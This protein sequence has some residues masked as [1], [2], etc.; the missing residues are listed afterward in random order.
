MG[1]AVAETR[2]GRRTAWIG[3]AIVLVGVAVIRLRLLDVPLERDEGE[4]AY[5]GARILD[6]VPPFAGA[7]T[8]KLP[9]T[10]ACYAVAMALF[11]R[12][13]AGIRTGLLLAN[14]ATIVLV[15]LAA[16]RLWGS[17]AGLAA[18][19]AFAGV[20]LSTALLGIYGHAT[21]FV[22][23]AAVGGFAALLLPERPLAGGRLLAA[24]ALF[25]LAIL[26]KQQG[27]VFA[28]LAASALVR[29]GSA[30][31]LPWFL[32]GVAAPWAAT[33]AL[34]AA[35]GTFDAFWFWTVEYAR[36]YATYSSLGHGL[37]RLGRR[38]AEA[39]PQLL[40]IA[41]L[42]LGG[43]A[44]LVA[45][46]A[47]RRDR[48]LLPALAGFAFAGTATGFYFRPHYLLLMAPA[49]AFLAA[50]ATERLARKRPAL[51]LAAIA[52]AAAQTVWAQR[53]LFFVATP[54]RVS[55]TLY[56]ASPFPEAVEVA[57]VLRER[58]APGD[59][60]AV[61]GS[62]PE[63]PFYAGLPSATGYLY[64]YGLM[65]AQP[66]ARRMQEQLIDEIERGRPRFV[67]YV[68][69]DT[70]WDRTVLSER[71][72]FDWMDRYLPAHYRTIGLVEILGPEESR[73]RWDEEVAGTGFTDTTHLVVLERVDL[74]GRNDRA[75]E[76]GNAVD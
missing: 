69:T 65:E 36:R 17:L 19:A 50:V 71:L 4:Y 31:R 74:D 1:E 51:A 32:A 68:R 56:A 62:E 29:T 46:G 43:V 41:L 33:A 16:R 27:A 14:A 8:M 52:L 55:R 28:A 45:R 61:L 5:V 26:M 70:S 21:H 18:A 39:G 40:G 48:E 59:S 63:I 30:R 15:F 57:R 73:Y 12:T 58:A 9:G 47:S 64:M 13:I 2:G 11:G 3:L 67:V 49:I 72:V 6:G 23:L 24:G 37:E 7:Y 44:A 34:L 75:Y 38:L 10:P 53:D 76:S 60:I 35:A 54:T 66:F 20:T 42:A 22:L 25:G